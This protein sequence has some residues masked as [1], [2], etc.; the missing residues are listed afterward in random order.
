V[1]ATNWKRLTKGVKVELGSELRIEV[2]GMVAAAAGTKPCEVGKVVR[3]RC[4][5]RKGTWKRAQPRGVKSHLRD[6]DWMV[7]EGGFGH[8]CLFHGVMERIWVGNSEQWCRN[9]GRVK[10]K[11]AYL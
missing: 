2:V 4:W 7:R 9:W 3:M 5:L 11:N 1:V 6:S 8:A 10:G